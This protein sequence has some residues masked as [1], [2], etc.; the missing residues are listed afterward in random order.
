MCGLTVRTLGKGCFAPVASPT[1]EGLRAPLW[2]PQSRSRPAPA[3][4]IRA[5]P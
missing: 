3:P 4:W 1:K 2:N 5:P